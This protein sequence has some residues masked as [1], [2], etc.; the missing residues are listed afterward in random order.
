MLGT[1]SEG[2]SAVVRATA[3]SYSGIRRHV[4]MLSVL[5]LALSI[6][7]ARTVKVRD[8]VNDASQDPSAVRLVEHHIHAVTCAMWWAR[9][10]EVTRRGGRPASSQATTAYITAT[11]HCRRLMR[12]LVCAAGSC[13]AHDN[14]VRCSP[15]YWHGQ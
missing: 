10:A 2:S 9:K 1:T 11:K 6:S 4:L 8:E 15:W 7:L 14:H 12:R 3:D 5:E 13:I